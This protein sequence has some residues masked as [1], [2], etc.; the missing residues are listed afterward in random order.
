MPKLCRI[1]RPIDG[2][3][4]L[5]ENLSA[6]VKQIAAGD[7]KLGT[8]ACLFITAKQIAHFAQM[9][10]TDNLD[11]AQAGQLMAKLEGLASSSIKVVGEECPD[12]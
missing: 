3:L 5:A 9:A 6:C 12:A 7:R 4:V 1:N 8:T 11:P 10:L 2:L